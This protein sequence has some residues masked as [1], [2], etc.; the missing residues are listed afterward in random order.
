[1]LQLFKLIK[2]YVTGSKGSFSEGSFYSE[3]S[4]ISV[5]LDHF[6]EII[7]FGIFGKGSKISTNQKLE[8]CAFSDKLKFK[9][10]LQK[11]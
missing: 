1:M 6:F 10:L 5:S 7:E 9:T 11:Y 3:H 8:N 4:Y 2:F